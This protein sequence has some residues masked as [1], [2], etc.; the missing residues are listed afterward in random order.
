MSALWIVKVSDEA[1]CND[2]ADIHM[3][4]WDLSSNPTSCPQGLGIRGTSE[5]TDCLPQFKEGIYKRDVS[6]SAFIN[7]IWLIIANMADDYPGKLSA[8]TNGNTMVKACFSSQNIPK[9]ETEVKTQ[10]LYP[11]P[12]KEQED[13]RW[14]GTSCTYPGWGNSGILVGGR[15]LEQ[16]H[17]GCCHNLSCFPVILRKGLEQLDSHTVTPHCFNK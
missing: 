6:S 15:N 11:A 5:L 12:T 14:G 2:C 1:K 13:K 4:K 17:N 3:E 8:N 9:S 16:S 7:I 10:F